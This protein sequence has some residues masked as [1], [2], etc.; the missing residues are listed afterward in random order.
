MS[1]GL[2]KIER[3]INKDW[4]HPSNTL[5]WSLQQVS[6][7]RRE[8][9]IW[10]SLHGL[11]GGLNIYNGP[12][13]RWRRESTVSA[14]TRGLRSQ[15]GL[16]LNPAFATFWLCMSSGL[17]FLIRKL[18]TGPRTAEPFA[19]GSLVYVRGPL[20]D[21]SPHAHPFSLPQSVWFPSL[22]NRVCARVWYV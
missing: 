15:R 6:P 7:G 12:G 17:G 11:C 21:S 2:P 14:P 3:D 22:N 20:V 4:S 5:P 19:A 1:S 10:V 9:E 16:G 13:K 8:S 18:G